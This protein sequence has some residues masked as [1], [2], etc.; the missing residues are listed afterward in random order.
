MI[1]SGHHD[2]PNALRRAR[3]RAAGLAGELRRAREV[4]WPDTPLDQEA[5]RRTENPFERILY[6]DP[7]R[8]RPATRGERC[9]GCSPI[10]RECMSAYAERIRPA[11]D[12]DRPARRPPVALDRIR[13]GR[14]A[15]GRGRRGLLFPIHSSCRRS[16]DPGRHPRPR[17]RPVDLSTPL[18]LGVTLRRGS[19]ADRGHPGEVRGRW[20]A[21]RKRP[22]GSTSLIAWTRRA[23]ILGGHDRAVKATRGRRFGPNLDRGLLNQFRRGADEGGA[24]VLCRTRGQPAVSWLARQHGGARAPANGELF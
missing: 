3:G 18:G 11:R 17:H 23:A 7:T 20:L 19:W 5:D 21:P 15:N 10:S 9:V 1:V 4:L 12:G 14:G 22:A 8:S 13:L 6:I 2:G 24:R 16:G